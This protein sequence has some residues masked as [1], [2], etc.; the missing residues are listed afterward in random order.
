MAHNTVDIAK[1]IEEQVTSPVTK[2][3]L[4]TIMGVSSNDKYKEIIRKMAVSRHHAVVVIEDKDGNLSVD[5]R[6]S[7]T[8]RKAMTALNKA[9]P[10]GEFGGGGVRDKTKTKAYARKQARAKKLQAQLAALRVDLGDEG[11]PD[12]PDADQTDAS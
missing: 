11:M 5:A 12:T 9:Q 6:V 10:L 1:A 8:I 3:A 7:Q 4:M 2:D